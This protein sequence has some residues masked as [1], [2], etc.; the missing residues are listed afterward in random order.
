MANSALS[1]N[2]LL[3]EIGDVHWELLSRG[4]EQPTTE[5]TDA[6]GNRLYAAFVRISYNISPLSEFRE[7]DQLSFKGVIKRFGHHAYFSKVAGRSGS[8]YL[9]A[10]L[11]TSFSS[12]NA[13]DNNKF[14]NGKPTKNGINKIA[15]LDTA[16]EFYTQLRMLKKGLIKDISANGETFK[17]TNSVL[18]TVHHTI[19]PY[20]EINGA[21]LLYFAAYPM[22][23]D[24]GASRFMKHTMGIR[25]FDATYHTTFRDVFYFANCNADDQIRIELNTIEHVAGN[26]LKITTTLYRESDNKCI[27]RILT[28]KQKTDR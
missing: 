13:N 7:N 18:E 17:I 14:S 25:D 2:W 20:Y 24:E 22:I 27:A 8:K 16:P 21:G 1:E 4:L 5:F 11:A 23:A 10:T 15:A 19:N 9:H 3:R 6:E 26:S 28:I 12:K